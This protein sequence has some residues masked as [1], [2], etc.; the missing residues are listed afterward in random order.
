[1]SA[2]VLLNLLNNSGKINKMRGLRFFSSGS[3]LFVKTE[4]HTSLWNLWPLDVNNEPS[5]VYSETCLKRPLK[6][7]TKNWFS[8]LIIA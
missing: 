8:R 6:M 1:M 5:Q 2:H 7:K 4:L 3:A